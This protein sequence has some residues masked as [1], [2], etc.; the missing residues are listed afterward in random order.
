MS[1]DYSYGWQKLH[2]AVLALVGEGDQRKRLVNAL[3]VCHILKARS[4]EHHLPEDTQIEFNEFI[5]KMTSMEAIEGEGAITATVSFLNEKELRNAVRKIVSF[6][7]SV[8]RYQ[9]PL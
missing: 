2:G 3:T 8:C 9:E 4:H 1:R 7:D 5:K 6:Y